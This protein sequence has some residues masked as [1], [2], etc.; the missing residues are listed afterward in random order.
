MKNSLLPIL[1]GLLWSSK[2]C[3]SFQTIQP[4]IT[5]KIPTS[6]SLFVSTTKAPGAAELDTPWEE[7]GFE[8]RTT[9]SH[10]QLKYKDGKWGK[11]EL[12]KVRGNK[13]IIL[14]PLTICQMKKFGFRC[15]VMI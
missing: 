2:C 8:Y 15:K 1:F 12:V 14:R 7:L 4:S 3:L 10:L 9:N 6:T 13:A 11:P 5:N